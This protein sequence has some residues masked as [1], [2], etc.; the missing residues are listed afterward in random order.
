MRKITIEEIEGIWVNKDKLLMFE[1]II[2]PNKVSFF[3][4]VRLSDNSILFHKEGEIKL[5]DNEDEGDVSIW[6]NDSFEIKI[7]QLNIESDEISIEI[8]E[9]GRYRMKKS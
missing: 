9:K 8:A 7:W 5:V 6:F 1:L 3:N 2:R 4:Q